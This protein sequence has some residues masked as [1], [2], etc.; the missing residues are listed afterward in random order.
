MTYSVRVT[1][2]YLITDADLSE[3]DELSRLIGELK[4]DTVPTSKLP[5][6]ITIPGGAEAELLGLC[7]SE[8]RYTGSAVPESITVQ[9]FTPPAPAIRIRSK[10][11]GE[12]R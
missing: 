2:T 6:F 3:D 11:R 8:E 1:W 4:R 7:L 12:N 9:A 5:Q 10:K